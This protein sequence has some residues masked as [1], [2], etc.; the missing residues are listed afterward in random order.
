MSRRRLSYAQ[1]LCLR[2]SGMAIQRAGMLVPGARVGV[3]V[4]GGV[5]SL[6]LLKVLKLRQA[7]LPFPF[8]ILAIHLNPGFESKNHLGLLPWLAGEG[9][10]AHLELTDHGLEAH[11]E[12][13]KRNSACFRCAW[14]RRKRLFD[15]CRSYKLSHL[16]LGHNLEDL[17]STFFLNLCRNGRVE[18]M[19]PCESFFQGR[20]T[21]IRPL[22]FVEKKFIRSAARQWNLPVWAN[23]CPSSGKTARSEM[24]AQ[25]K[26]LEGAIKDSR[27]SILNALSRWQLESCQTAGIDS[28]SKTPAR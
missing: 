22:L 9:I 17:A 5:D 6:V 7:I 14:L 24:E 23:A 16:A 13:N 27:R 3:A 20:L 4:S 26:A 19:K 18:G 25:I 8:E 28:G 15:L 10:A 21:M 11:S 2:N 1:T 12:K